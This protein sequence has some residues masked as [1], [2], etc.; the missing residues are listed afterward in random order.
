MELA[1]LCR[2]GSRLAARTGR[3]GAFLLF[4]ALLDFTYGYSLFTT[5]APLKVLD[6]LLPWEAWAGIWVGVG[7]V[8]LAGAFVRRDRIAFALAAGIKGAWGLLYLDLWAVQHVPRA[9]VAVPIWL[10]FSATVLLVAGWPE[11][12]ARVPPTP[13]G[14]PAIIA[15][16]DP[17]DP[18]EPELYE[19]V[20]IIPAEP[21][22]GDDRE[23]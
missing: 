11:P 10:A 8:C 20:I 22:P 16:A 17:D 6:L 2:A 21:Q 15:P 1:M 7:A 19:P 5:S 18:R 4:L 23:D 13:E 9:W 3:R 14:L 12:P